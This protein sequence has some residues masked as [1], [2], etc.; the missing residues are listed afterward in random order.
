MRSLTVITLALLLSACLTKPNP[1]LCDTATDCQDGFMCNMNPDFGPTNQCIEEP[2]ECNDMMPCPNALP[3]CDNGQCRGCRE[4]ECEEGSVCNTETGM[5]EIPR[6]SDDMRCES[7]LPVCG[8]SGV[9]EPCTDGDMTACSDFEGLPHCDGGQC[10]G[11]RNNDDCNDGQLCNQ[12]VKQCMG[13]TEH[14]QCDSDVC[15]Y[16]DNGG[17]CIPDSDVIYVSPDG[18]D[19]GDGNNA[20]NRRMPCATITKAL[21]LIAPN[22]G[23][24]DII[25]VAGKE[26]TIYTGRYDI[27]N[28][29]VTLLGDGA[30]LDLDGAGDNLPVVHVQ[31]ETANVTI[32]D[33]QITGA[34]GNTTG[35]MIADMADG[36]HCN[37]GS[38]VYLRRVVIHNNRNNGVEGNGC[39]QLTV[40]RSTI[41]DNTLG[42][43]A[44][45]SSAFDIKHNVIFRNG[46]ANDSSWGGVQIFNP[47]GYDPQIFDLNTITLNVANSGALAAGV[48]CAVLTDTVDAYGNIIYRQVHNT[49]VNAN[50]CYFHYSNI[51][52]M[53]REEIFPGMGNINEDPLFVEMDTNFRLTENSPG[54]NSVN[55]TL[56][57]CPVDDCFDRDG[58]ARPQDTG[59]D[60]GAFEYVP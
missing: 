3:F 21:E 31:G 46:H 24:R 6:C 2:P 51:G 45:L 58:I 22:G 19:A 33:L 56:E 16:D 5:C 9:C 32:K 8:E 47:P 27:M 29:T 1:L 11:C 49:E 59:Y 30:T 43:I 28:K 38:K 50:R 36:V 52:M 35:M 18:V 57:S 13:C 48:D 54:Q 42:G 23:S 40:E 25:F 15:D 17:S 37:N 39:G 55:I 60:M 7:S 4:A 10:V 53:N 41:N 14:E 12:E 34:T 44:V 26:D 20:C